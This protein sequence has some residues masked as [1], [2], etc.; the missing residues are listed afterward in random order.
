MSSIVLH[1]LTRYID[2]PGHS[3]ALFPQ[4]PAISTLSQGRCPASR[5]F[6]RHYCAKAVLQRAH[7]LIEYATWLC[8]QRLEPRMASGHSRHRGAE[9]LVGLL[10]DPA[11]S[12]IQIGPNSRFVDLTCSFKSLANQNV[13]VSFEEQV[14]LNFF[15]ATL[16]DVRLLVSTLPTGR[17]VQ[18]RGWATFVNVINGQKI[19]RIGGLLSFIA[20][21]GKNPPANF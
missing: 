14:N 7:L 18:G 1:R 6:G 16:D 5:L 12:L 20:T 21:K 11:R 15:N 8:F 13:V 3:G 10:D 2:P 9:I 4:S 17:R 19:F